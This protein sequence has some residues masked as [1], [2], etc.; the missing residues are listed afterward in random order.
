MIRIVLFLLII[1]NAN[2]FAQTNDTLDKDKFTYRST[3]LSSILPGSGQ[4]HNSKIKPL[5]L[6]N[7]LWWKLPIIYGGLGTATYLIQFNHKEFRTI[8]DERL[9]RQ[10]GNNAVNYI[11]Y[12]SEQIKLI[13]NEYRRLRD[14]SIISL[15]GVYL[16]QIIDANVE[17]Q[18]FLFDISDN[19]SFKFKHLNQ[20]NLVS[21]YLFPQIS[22]NFKL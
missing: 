2:C 10:N 4:I 18:L 12:S 13:Q 8:K 16:L 6:N 1:S 22:L 20:N 19:L 3:V 7:R 21:S 17:A 11:S 14:F 9:S 15:I 5:N